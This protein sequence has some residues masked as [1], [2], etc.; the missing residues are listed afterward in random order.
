MVIQGDAVPQT[1]V[2][3]LIGLYQAGRFPLD[4]LVSFYSFYEINKAVK[5]SV[6]GKVVKPV[7]LIA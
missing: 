6:E 3:F 4:R 7:I 2:P 1:F 5:E